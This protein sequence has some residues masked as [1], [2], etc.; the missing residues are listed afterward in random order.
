LSIG[1]AAKA[2]NRNF[3]KEDIAKFDEPA[4]MSWPAAEEVF[5]L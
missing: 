5:G 3:A 4:G 2:C 1:D